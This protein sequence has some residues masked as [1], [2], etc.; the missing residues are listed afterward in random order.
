[1]PTPL[2]Y[3]LA[4]D[5][6]PPTPS[7]PSNVISWSYSIVQTVSI[8][9]ATAL[10]TSIDDV[11]IKDLAIDTA[12]GDMALPPRYVVGA[13][14]IVQR[15]SIRFQ[16]WLGEWFLDQRQGVPYID[17]VFVKAPDLALITRLFRRVVTSTPGIAQVKSMSLDL[18]RPS[19]TL[20]VRNLQAVL[21]SGSTLVATSTPFLVARG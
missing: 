9:G 17:Q 6:S 14:A 8:V 18:D 15:L 21:V 19:R 10:A 12:T 2:V 11:A 4:P 1:M 3:S 16:F 13:D 5:V 7:P 20:R